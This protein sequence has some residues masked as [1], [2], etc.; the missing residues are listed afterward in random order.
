M[1]GQVFTQDIFGRTPLNFGGA[2]AADSAHINLSLNCCD[3][4]GDPITSAGLVTQ[5]LQIQ[6]QQPITRLYELGTQ[7]CYFVAGRPQG[8]ANIAK[9]LGPGLVMAELY[10]CLGNVC[11][12]A[13]NDVCFCIQG[14][15]SGGTETNFEAM[16][17][18]LKNVVMQSLG[19]TVQAQDMLVNEQMS[20]FFTAM[21]AI[22]TVACQGPQNYVTCECVP[23]VVGATPPC[24]ATH[25]TCVDG[26]EYSSL[27]HAPAGGTPFQSGCTSAGPSVGVC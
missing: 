27:A 9:I 25:Y 5:Q 11:N 13:T 22:D 12:A 20:L 1:A 15:C 16:Q 26:V 4:F 24:G 19:M 6:Y 10:S 21:L 14:G 7:N 3:C 2:F 17:L 23:A 8:S 18:C